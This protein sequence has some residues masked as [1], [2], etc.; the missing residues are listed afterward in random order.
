MEERET[1]FDDALINRR[2]DIF[3]EHSGALRTLHGLFHF[4]DINANCDE[5]TVQEEMRNEFK[6]QSEHELDKRT[7]ESIDEIPKAETLKNYARSALTQRLNDFKVRNVEEFDEAVDFV[8]ARV[9]PACRNAA[10]S[11]VAQV[12]LEPGDSF[13]KRFQSRTIRKIVMDIL[14]ER[15][16]RVCYFTSQRL[17]PTRVKED[18]TIEVVREIAH[19]LNVRFSPANLRD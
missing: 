7:F 5:K 10:F 14:T 9:I 8:R 16:Y 17:I 3:E 6:Y 18:N 11:G 13:H 12:K 2:Y 1:D 4:K 19:G 15:G